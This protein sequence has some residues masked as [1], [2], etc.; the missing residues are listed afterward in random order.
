[1]LS[2]G[3]IQKQTGEVESKR[4]CVLAEAAELHQAQAPLP[5]QFL[6]Y[7]PWWC[8]SMTPVHG[9]HDRC[10]CRPIW[11]KS[12]SLWRGQ[13]LEQNSNFN[14][15]HSYTSITTDGMAGFALPGLHVRAKAN[16]AKFP[17]WRRGKQF[18]KCSNVWYVCLCACLLACMCVCNVV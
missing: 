8:P 1:M 17:P 4:C 14:F 15:I 12:K 10:S 2:Q 5:V 9:P 18:G 13:S 3:K 16:L 7:P 6:T 11:T